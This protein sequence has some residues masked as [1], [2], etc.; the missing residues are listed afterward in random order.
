MIVIRLMGGLGNQLFQYAAGRQ[1]SERLQTGFFL[2]TGWFD[3][4]DPSDTKRSYELDV[5]QIRA[6]MADRELLQHFGDTDFSMYGRLKTVLASLGKYQKSKFYDPGYHDRFEQLRDNLYLKGFFQSEKYFVPIAGELRKELRFRELPVYQQHPLYQQIAAA[7]SVSLHV[8]RGDYLNNQAHGICNR[9]YYDKA[10][11]FIKSNAGSGIQFYVFTDDPNGI[12]LDIDLPGVV[13]V[14]NSDHPLPNID[15]F[16]M[17]SCKHHILA[18]STY[19][20]WAAWMNICKDKIVL[21]PEMWTNE[22]KT[23]DIGLDL[24]GMQIIT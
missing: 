5:F 7:N 2:D 9:L 1:L 15:L 21:A 23:R 13:Y 6:N 19:S 4:I 20:W 14:D 12:R 22:H 8:R 16:L 24:P 18:N 17:S 3:E 10:I 11:E